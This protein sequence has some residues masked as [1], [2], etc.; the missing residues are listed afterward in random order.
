[1]KIKKLLLAVVMLGV[2]GVYAQEGSSPTDIIEG[3]Y[4]GKTI[5]LRDFATLQEDPTRT[6]A[7]LRIV[8]NGRRTNEQVN[9]DALPLGQD[10][11]RQDNF[12]DQYRFALEQ[13]FIGASRS[14]SGFVPPDPTG[15]VG[16]NHYVHAVNSLIKIFDKTGSLLVGPIALGTFLG[17]GTNSGDPIVM[18][19]QLADRFFV[20]QF[21]TAT[22]SLVIGVSDSPDPTGAY[23]VYEFIFDGFPDYPHYTVWPNG[24]YLTA[25]KI[26]GGPNRIY[27][28]ERDVIIAGGASP[29]LVGFPL[30]GLVQNPSTIESPEP[31]NLL[32]TT[33]PAN[34]PGYIT[35]LQDDGWSGVSVDH[36]KVWEVDVDW[37]TIGNSTISAP[38]EIPTTPFN[39]TFAPFGQ[40]DVAQPGTN[41]KI[42]MIGGVI[43]YAANY[44]SFPTHNSWVIT[45]NVDIDNQ[46]TSGI[47]WIELRNDLTNDWSIF[48]EGTYAPA[49]GHSRFMGSAAMDE[50]GNIGMG[51]NIASETLPVGIKFTGRFDGDP[52]G[53]MTQAETEIVAGG[54]VQAFSNRFGDY[55]HLSMDPNN[56]TFWHTAE[57]FSSINAWRTRIASFSLSSNLAND[58]GVNDITTPEDGELTASETVEVVIR[59]FGLAPQTNI[60]LEL[61][62]DGNLVASETFVGVINPNLA[63]TYTFTQTLDLSTPGQTYSIE[64]KTVLAG[65]QLAVNDSFTKD[66]TNLLLG[67]DDFG[68]DTNDLIITSLPNNQFE[69]SLKSDYTGAAYIA[70]YNTLGQQ[71][72]VK[73]VSNVNGE[74]RLNLDMA[75]AATG[76]YLIKVG[77]LTSNASKTG[78]IIVK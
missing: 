25:N 69:I 59:N 52:L 26:G 46:N 8:A 42:D 1:M 40:G 4:V 55:S 39:S 17:N 64:A 57:Y 63:E 21:G 28:M 7:E 41:Q 70:V 15:A 62:L 16:P 71:M 60:P 53:V 3:T 24:Y 2:F 23:N 9:M 74:F 14:E 51:F 30:P 22:N 11:L 66:V 50:L 33:F 10:P 65:D 18:Y 32:G 49:D 5:P 43:S 29:Q 6:V 38:L 19:D 78:K 12:G 37:V 58:V 27:V 20:S 56:L 68:L 34:V 72:G 77:G 45:F 73:A 36:L 48:Q 31:A 54:G 47:R 35:F 75:Y 13:N 44:R 67:I 76:V 61:Y